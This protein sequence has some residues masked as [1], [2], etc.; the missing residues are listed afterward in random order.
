VEIASDTVTVPPLTAA[1]VDG[2]YHL[3]DVAHFRLRELAVLL[4]DLATAI[5]KLPQ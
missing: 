5:A 3:L 1:D 2:L 4:D